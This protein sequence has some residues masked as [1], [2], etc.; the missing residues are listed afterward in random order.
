MMRGVMRSRSIDRA[1]G[2]PRGMI[3]LVVLLIVSLLAILGA[4]FAYRMR[5]DLSAV[6]A[7]SDQL[8]AI[9][10]ARSG[11][12][13]ALLILRTHRLDFDKWYDNKE[14]F[15]R[16]V[17]WAPGR[18]GG[19]TGLADEVEEGQPAWR[20]SVIAPDVDRAL[21]DSMAGFRYGVVD[22]TSKLN[23][24]VATREQLIRLF[25]QLRLENVTP[26]EL[27]EA[28]MDWR[29]ADETPR[30]NGAETSYYQTLTP[31][32]RCK[33]A[34]LETVEEVL[35]IKGFNG[36]I[37]YGED[38]NRNGHL[39]PNEDDGEKGMFPPDNADGVLNRGLYAYATVYSRDRNAAN[40]NTPRLNINSGINLEQLPEQLR[41]AIEQ[42]IRPEVFEFIKQAKAKGHQFKS[43]AELLQDVRIK[44]KKQAG[45]GK[46]GKGGDKPGKGG[47]QP[48]KGGNQPGAGG[49]PPGP[50]GGAPAGPGGTGDV[51]GEGGPS[52]PPDEG[53][54]V[55][56]RGPG[57]RGGPGGGRRGGDRGDPRRPGGRRPGGPDSGAPNAGDGFRGGGE[58]R[59]GQR[60]PTEED[61]LG[62][63]DKNL[64][65]RQQA[66]DDGGYRG[67]QR[68]PT[69]EDLIGG[70]SDPGSDAVRRPDDNRGGGRGDGRGPGDQPAPPGRGDQPPLPDENLED[71]QP[72]DGMRPADP[73]D[74]EAQGDEGGEDEAQP[75]DTV[76]P[77]PVQP[78]DMPA[79]MD[80][81][82]ADAK[83][84]QFG[85]INVNTAPREV[86][87]ALPG[88]DERDVDAI[89]ASRATLSPQDKLT[90][91]WLVA[92]G[93]LDPK[94]FAK[95]GPYVTARSLQ[96]TIESI[97]FA[98]HVGTFKRL[99][100]VVE[101]RGQVEQILYWRDISVLGVA[102]PLREDEW[103]NVV[104]I[105]R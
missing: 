53:A 90:P 56:G 64:G 78:Q 17:V 86:L 10:A 95:I 98:D 21:S 39:D 28:L 101:M 76:I 83:P 73:Q 25:E 69:E 55:D 47:D 20:F 70:R 2:S 87:M 100:V 5:A 15:R 77:T 33:N 65:R 24:N 13:W 75:G 8:Q 50:G 62:P 60:V 92:Q 48:G 22:E 44:A 16:K 71:E 52:V 51:G 63:Q 19:T 57:G 18:T 32:Y 12:D 46:G 89:V 3:L 66:R 61:L 9:Q 14:A 103:K 94:K 23:L 1:S 36:R 37:L 68:V 34:P 67:G 54:G 74:R 30:P 26:V 27:A 7:E 40:D 31:A 84:I 6:S 29:D 85:L 81:L 91:A 42:E 45:G 43:V 82:T 59:G 102:Y 49:N 38:Y 80:R 88:L 105:R 99:Q 93:V 4:T 79:I 96:Y 41:T 104:D 97:G 72:G 11:V 58:Y 35:L